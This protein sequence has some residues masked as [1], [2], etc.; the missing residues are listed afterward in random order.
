MS[1]THTL[2][3]RPLPG[4]EARWSELLDALDLDE[5]TESFVARVAV[6]PGYDPAPLPL[7]ELRRTGRNSF[8]TLID[9]LR[10]GGFSGAV[11]VSTDVGVSRARAGIPLE[12]LMTAIR[13]DFTVLWEALTRVAAPSD[14]E[15]VIRH[16]GDVLSTVDDYIV[17]VQQAYTAEQARMRAEE[18]SVRQ[19]VIAGLFQ[20]ADPTAE[21]LAT[22]ASA[23][24]LD[25]DDALIVAAAGA[26]DTPALRVIVSAH[27]R[28]GGT[29]FTHHLGD[30]L[31]A[32]TRARRV[33]PGGATGR[34][35]SRAETGQVDGGEESRA[36]GESR[37][38]GSE[39][40]R[41]GAGGLRADEIED[42]LAEARV[43]VVAAAGLGSL[44]R[45][46][47]TARD[48]AQVFEAGETGAMTWSR[49][50][51]RLAARALNASGKSVISD[52]D[53]ALARCGIAERERL[54]EA[55]R[56]YLE[57]GSIGR[58]A[59]IL[60]CHRNTVAN[61][62]RRF[63]EVTGVDPTIPV[64]AARLVVAWA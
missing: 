29:M 32:F 3:D 12:A 15:L 34:G 17:Q 26:E 5:L 9:G 45:S 30:V 58:T 48:L 20:D 6:V 60:Y 7:S 27:E 37:I 53:D 54:V 46:A 41:T 64:Q 63:A 11:A 38:G 18:S 40:P 39:E 24:G 16:T 10:A 25:V 49:G 33:R 62:L 44:R 61:R 22:I 19:G 1:A 31:I 55:V 28:A 21:R 4:D 23:L 52:V 13:L 43:G 57:T 36:G 14:A 35:A 59:G 42:R 50:W 56:A 47:L 8:A 2:H 51:A